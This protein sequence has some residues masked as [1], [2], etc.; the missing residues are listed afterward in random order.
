M[1]QHLYASILKGVSFTGWYTS[2]GVV[3][4]LSLV[5]DILLHPRLMTDTREI[6][7]PIVF[8]P[9][10]APQLTGFVS[11]IVKLA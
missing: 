8:H 10:S 7:L 11:S 6:G 2:I 3:P 4:Y 1:K 9:P 5:L